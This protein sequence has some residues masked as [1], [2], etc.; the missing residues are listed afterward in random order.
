MSAVVSAKSAQAPVATAAREK[1]LTFALGQELLALG[2]LRVKE[3]LGY[4]EPTAI[5]RMPAHV[6]GVINLRGTVIPV[7][8]LDARFGRASRAVG[9]RSCILIVEADF[10]GEKLILG[11]VVDAVNEVLSIAEADVGP[12][13]EF[14]GT[15]R[16]RFLRGLVRNQGRFVA[17]LDADTVFDMAELAQ[18]TRQRERCGAP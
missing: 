3:I 5:L 9:R 15:I 14:G 1:Y 16:A 11:I 18:L 13:P 4:R 7:L 6:R 17:L 10:N 8:D 12:V 2:I